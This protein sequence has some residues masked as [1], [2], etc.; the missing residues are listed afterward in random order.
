MVLLAAALA[1]AF[2]YLS[3]PRALPIR[4]V[5]VKGD[6]RHLSPALLER[7]AGEVVRG[8]FFNVNVETVRATLLAEP[9]VKGVTVRRTW[10]DGLALYVREQVPVARWGDAALLNRD[11]EVFVPARESWP[12]GLPALTGPEGTEALVLERWRYVQQELDGY[13]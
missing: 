11:A 4:Y 5:R 6:F 13:G 2:V 1:A 3:D 10:P 7:T 12:E 9:W 8:G